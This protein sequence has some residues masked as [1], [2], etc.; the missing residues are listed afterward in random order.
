MARVV[1]V[2]ARAG[3]IKFLVAA[4]KTLVSIESV[5]EMVPGRSLVRSQCRP[6]SR[7]PCTQGV[8]RFSWDV[9]IASRPR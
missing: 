7:T 2:Q 6:Q 1:H 8:L 9:A 5:G 4:L 3:A